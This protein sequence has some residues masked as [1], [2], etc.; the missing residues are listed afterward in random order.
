MEWW[1]AG[2]FL[3]GSAIPVFFLWN[4]L[5]ELSH[6]L[7]LKIYLRSASAE[8]TLWP[9]KNEGKFYWGRVRYFYNGL[10]PTPPQQA[11]V[12][13]A[14]RWLN[15]LALLCFP[16]GTLFGPWGALVWMTIWGGGIIDGLVGSM[17][18]NDHSDMPRYA[19]I[20][21][22]ERWAFRVAGWSLGISSFTTGLSLLVI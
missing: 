4:T 3:L 16:L 6:F 13:F 12:S 8:F 19:K 9:H 11:W 18:I 7:V 22:I 21:K 10:P 5:H 14:P 20:W 2:L 17:G 1:H 15:M